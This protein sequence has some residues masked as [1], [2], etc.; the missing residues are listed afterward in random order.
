MAA[1][2][3]SALH[4]WAKT[5]GNQDALVVAGE[6][7]TYRQLQDWSSRIA[8]TLVERGIE[9]GQRVGVLGRTR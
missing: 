7:L 3:G 6:S 4:W 5:K 9:R 1:T 8:R 2:V